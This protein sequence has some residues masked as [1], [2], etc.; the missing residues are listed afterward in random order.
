MSA[1]GTICE[2]RELYIHTPIGLWENIAHLEEYTGGMG[3]VPTAGSKGRAPGQGS[4]R[5]WYCGNTTSGF[6]VQ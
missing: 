1:V 6:Y 3:A 2:T 4:G 5:W